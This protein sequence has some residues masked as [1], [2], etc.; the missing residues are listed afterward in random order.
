MAYGKAALG[1]IFISHSS[2]DKAWVRRFE[3]R[4]RDAGY[5]TWRPKWGQI[6]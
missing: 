3:K 4:V 1:K 5:D 2:V 6:R